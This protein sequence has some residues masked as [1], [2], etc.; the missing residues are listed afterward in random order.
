M[1]YH[2]KQKIQVQ[3]DFKEND[4][5]RSY[6]NY[7][8]IIENQT[9]ST[10]ML[11]SNEEISV[12]QEFP[13][14]LDWALK[15]NQKFGKKGGGKRIS[16]HIVVLLEGYFLAGNLN[17]SDRYSTQKMWSELTQLVEEGSLEETDI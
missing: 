12:H 11:D 13:L 6:A 14:K 1:L 17:K 15:E 9:L 10:N 7:N 8:I 5:L 4:Y 3:F 16:K 2:R